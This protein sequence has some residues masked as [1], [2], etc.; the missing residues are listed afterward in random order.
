MICG[1]MLS[2]PHYQTGAETS[3]EETEGIA[4]HNPKRI[5]I[6]LATSI[7]NS[8]DTPNFPF[9]SPDKQVKLFGF[10][11]IIAVKIR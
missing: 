7:N 6:F 4:F 11:L 5:L 1:L 3:Q 8:P 10:K 2:L 9:T